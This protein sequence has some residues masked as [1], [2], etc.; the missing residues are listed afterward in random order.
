MKQSDNTP[1]FVGYLDMPAALRKFYI[2]LT[3]LMLGFSALVGFSIASLQSSSGAASWN[4][5][6]SV[7]LEG[8]LTVDPYPVLHRID[9][10]NPGQIESV[11]L[12]NQGKYSAEEFARPSMG[13]LV[14]VTGFPIARGGWTMLEI[15][16][17]EDIIENQ[18]ELSN[19]KKEIERQVEEKSIGAVVLKGEIADSKCFLGVMKPGEG[20]VHKACAE[21]CLL[22][23]IPSMLVVRDRHDVR[24]GYILILEDGSSASTLLA[25]RAADTVEIHGELFRKGDLLYLKM[26]SEG[27][28]G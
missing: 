21:V 27:L 26:S 16:S 25:D 17:A 11:L 2:P 20:S 8:L 1:F 10:D 28:E 6:S 13:K 23:G 22:G 24:Y 14:S 18:S 3:I 9:P 15:T 4:T 19:Q 7:I 12:V 5:E